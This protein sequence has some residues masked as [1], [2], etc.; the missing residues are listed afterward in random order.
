[1]NP[2]S[3]AFD[4]LKNPDVN[5]SAANAALTTNATNRLLA[6]IQALAP[7]I[8]ARAGEIE[9]AR[10]IPLDLVAKLR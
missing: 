2:A 6:D 3:V 4:R 7:E 1:M 8:T 5:N 10:R 9:A